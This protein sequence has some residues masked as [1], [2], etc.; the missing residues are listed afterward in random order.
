MRVTRGLGV[1]TLTV[2]ILETGVSGVPSK[3][4]KSS[5]WAAMGPTITL[6]SPGKGALRSTPSWG[7]QGSQGVLTPPTRFFD[8]ISCHFS[9]LHGTNFFFMILGQVRLVLAPRIGIFWMDSFSDPPE[10]KMCC[11]GGL[12]SK[13][14]DFSVPHWNLVFLLMGASDDSKQATVSRKTCPTHIRS[15][16]MPIKLG[17]F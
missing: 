16:T 7:L 8:Q 14:A 4:Q 10:P 1:L 13:S 12:P 9:G 3:S 5:I 15:C 6:K 2:T 17:H 11:F